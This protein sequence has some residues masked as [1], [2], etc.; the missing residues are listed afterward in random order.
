MDSGYTYSTSET[1]LFSV[2]QSP[3]LWNTTVHSSV[4]GFA[5]THTSKDSCFSSVLEPRFVSYG[6]SELFWRNFNVTE[7]NCVIHHE[8]VRCLFY[9]TYTCTV[10]QS[11]LWNYNRDYNSQVVLWSAFNLLT[12][13]SV[14]LPYFLNC[15]IITVLATEI[16]NSFIK[17]TGHYMHNS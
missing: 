12:V 2:V 5:F 3:V 10:Y 4:Y 16:H 8:R 9:Y 11:D 14:V 13:S 7:V 17:G 15:W 6:Y 1:W